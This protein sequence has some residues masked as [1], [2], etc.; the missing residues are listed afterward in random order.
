MTDQKFHDG[1]KRVMDGS[2]L[3][4]GNYLLITLKSIELYTFRDVSV[5]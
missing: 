4:S 1:D 3:S 2:S 5:V